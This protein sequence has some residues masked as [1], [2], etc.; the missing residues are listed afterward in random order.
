MTGLFSDIELARRLE[1]AEGRANASFVEARARLAPEVGA[2]WIEVAGAYVLF[3]G[4]S[5]PC[6][7]SF[8]LGM[9]AEPAERDLEQIEE[10]YRQRGAPVWHEVSPLAGIGVHSML[11]NRGYRLAEM[12]SL[13]CQPLDFRAGAESPGSSAWSGDLDV[14][15][16]QAD[17]SEV[18]SRTAAA[19]WGEYAEYVDL[20]YDLSV[21]SFLREG[22]VSFLVEMKGRMV[23]TGSLFIVD[24][25]A[26]LAGASTIPEARRCGAQQAL[27]AARLRYARER[28]CRLAMMGAAPGS[29]SQRNAER[30]GFRIVYTRLKW[31]L[32][33][34]DAR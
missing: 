15:V 34:G 29:G 3:D 24:D 12:T 10:F 31:G 5:S 11:S 14:R 30:N 28:G 23:A 7:Q 33:V 25:I 22:A 17:E 26:L 18:W 4:V 8:G 19:G 21:V 16:A 1:M 2:E 32:G 13:L 6:T 27:L 20:I 9:L